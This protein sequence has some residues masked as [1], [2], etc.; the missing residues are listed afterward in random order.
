MNPT[1]G[2]AEAENC[3][4]SAAIETQDLDTN[5]LYIAWNYEKLVVDVTQHGIV[6]LR[7]KGVSGEIA[8]VQL[9]YDDKIM[10][11]ATSYKF[12]TFKEEKSFQ[13]DCVFFN[14]SRTINISKSIARI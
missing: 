5:L 11:T 12:L 8:R 4:I 14:H 1:S 7:P 9:F 6:F 3:V 13:F 10:S 2:V